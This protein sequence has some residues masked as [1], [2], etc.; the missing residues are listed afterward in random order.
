[1][2]TK[3]VVLLYEPMHEDA[4]N[5]LR[6]RYEVR[7][8]PSLEEEALLESVRD[9]D[10][11]I[12]RANGKISRRLIEHAPRLKVIGRHGVGVEAID[13]AAATERGIVVVN[14]PDANT[15]SVAEHCI[16]MMIALAKKLLP[17]DRAAR[18]AEWNARYELIGTELYGKTLGLIGFGRIGRRVA[19]MGHAAFQMP[20]IY[21]DVVDY[22]DA[23]R[24]L[25]AQ[26]MG[27]EDVLR[28]GDFVSVHVPLLA[29]TRNL[30]GTRELNLMK[31]SAF[32]INAARGEVVNEAALAAALRDKCIA[33]AGLDVFASEPVNADN[34][35][36]QF[37]NV[38][39]SPHMAAHTDEALRRMAMVA[40]DVIAVLD[41][42]EPRYRVA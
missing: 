40:T 42:K 8:A 11:I 41:G 22:P 23:E 28:R 16:G 13:L 37:D 20:I 33:G 39:L 2:M 18:R 32:L 10:A 25:G 3:P 4:V 7:M 17:A 27:L 24:A 19:E 36:F 26:R 34:P 14:T 15:E 21:F 5:L 12:I 38:V 29:S 31:R 6:A 1:M 35:L 30:I 9:V